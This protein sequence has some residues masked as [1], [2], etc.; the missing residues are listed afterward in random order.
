MRFFGVKAAARILEAI[1]YNIALPAALIT[2][3]IIHVIKLLKNVVHCKLLFLGQALGL[4]LRL[5]HSVQL[6]IE[7]RGS[8]QSH[9]FAP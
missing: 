4:C 9:L 2:R 5:W 7:Q 3:L 1:R 6:A 8:K